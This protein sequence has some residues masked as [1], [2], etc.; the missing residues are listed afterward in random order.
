MNHGRSGSHSED[1]SEVPQNRK[2]DAGD[3]IQHSLSDL[4]SHLGTSVQGHSTFTLYKIFMERKYVIN[5]WLCT[6]TSLGKNV[7]V[8]TCFNNS[9]VITDIQEEMSLCIQ[10]FAG[11]NTS[12]FCPKTAS[13][14]CNFLLRSVGSHDLLD[15]NIFIWKLDFV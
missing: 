1:V 2:R 14:H 6:L 12:F 3:W 11:Q 15:L 4:G 10:L 8:S 13:Y 9:Q 7:F 5:L